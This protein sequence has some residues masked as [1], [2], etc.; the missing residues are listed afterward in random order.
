MLAAAVVNARTGTR[1]AQRRSAPDPWVVRVLVG[2]DQDLH[3]D[4]F[5]GAGED[6]HVGMRVIGQPGK[7]C[8]GP[9]TQVGRRPKQTL[10][11]VAASA[12]A[13]DGATDADGAG[14]GSFAC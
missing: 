12:A 4:I 8:A 1:Q 2:Q 14:A 6:E 10:Q 5:G 7:G 3:M 9:E 11:P 13:V